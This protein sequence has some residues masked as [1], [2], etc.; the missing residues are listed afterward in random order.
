MTTCFS[1]YVIR[2]LW[3]WKL[4]QQVAGGCMVGGLQEVLGGGCAPMER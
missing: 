2:A 4:V 3:L 1:K